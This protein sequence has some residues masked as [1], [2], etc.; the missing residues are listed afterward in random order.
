MTANKYA[1]V[2]A[3][4]SWNLE[5]ARLARQHNDANLLCLP[6]RFISLEEAFLM[7]GSFLNAD[8]EGGRHTNR[9]AKIR[10]TN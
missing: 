8:F 4:L 6:A 5:T 1:G 10:I 7:V 2:R 3:A 9:V